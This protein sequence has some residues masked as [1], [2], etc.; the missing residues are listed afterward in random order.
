VEHPLGGVAHRLALREGGV[1]TSG[2]GR[3][4]WHDA[5]GFTHHLL[6]PATGRPAWTGLIQATAL[7]PTALEA[8]TLAKMALL[9]G[10]GGGRRLLRGFGGVVVHED[11]DVEV[12]GDPAAP[13]AVAA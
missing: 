6:D 3:R 1:A 13:A 5:A 9:S 2:I 10:A 7:A 12:V 4:L 8:E 11:G